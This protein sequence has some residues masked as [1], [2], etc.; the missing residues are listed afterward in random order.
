MKQRKGKYKKKNQKKV[1]DLFVNKKKILQKKNHIFFKY[2]IG[3]VLFFQKHSNI[4]LILKTEKKKHVITLTAGSCNVG[5]TKKQ[6]ISPF[7]INIIIKRL[8]DYCKLYNVYRIRFFLR[9]SINKHYYNII[10]YLSLY[11]IK[12]MEVGYVLHLPHNGTRGKNLRRI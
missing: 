3:H 7:N 4:F 9:S 12:V 5:S 11:N 6:K 8:K 2:G 1:T 10:K